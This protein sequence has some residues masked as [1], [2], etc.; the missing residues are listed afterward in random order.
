MTVQTGLPLDGSVR[1]TMEDRFGHNFGDVR[2]HA[3]DQAAASA[4]DLN[5]AA[6]S[7]GKHIVFG[8]GRYAPETPQGQRLIAHELAHVVQRDNAHSHPPING[9]RCGDVRAL[10]A[11][12]RQA[13][14]D[15][16]SGGRAD[17]QQSAPYSAVLRQEHPAGNTGAE[18]PPPRRPDREERFNLGRGGGRV[19][20]VLDRPIGMLT[21]KMK[22]KFVPT[23]VPEPWP[24]PA[25]FAQFKTDFIEAVT[26]RWSFKHFLVP[27]SECP[28]EPQ[29]IAVRMQVREV[30]ASE[31]FK[32]NVGYASSFTQSSV[33]GRTADLDVL[34]T[35]VRNDQPQVPAEHEFGHMLGLP[36]I[37]CDKNDDE[38]YGT[39]REEKAD[40]MGKGSFV[41]P[42]DYEP[43]AELMPAF[44]SCNYRVQQMSQI[45]T[46]RA[47]AIG[48]AIGGILGALGGGAAG[49]AIGAAV[50]GPIGAAIGGLIGLIGGGIGGF[51]AGRALATPEVP[52]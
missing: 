9:S 5:A 31:H 1:Q 7:T 49:L 11:D 41:S 21:A 35:S 27:Q 44:T 34:D 6:Y 29:R 39:S 45:P 52:S 2:I 46:S 17:V 26:S 48:G 51:F 20:A 37:R 50:G 25:R 36:H 38:C 24:S 40:V 19:D 14:H 12:A 30:T 32:V 15:V 22:V 33:G 47:P 4:N 10:E 13:A 28:G 16:T 43:F 42:R 18:S 23:N 3:D 8:A